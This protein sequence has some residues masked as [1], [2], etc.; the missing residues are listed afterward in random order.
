MKTLVI[1][2]TVPVEVDVP[3]D[4]PVSEAEIQETADWRRNDWS[5]GRHPFTSEQL[6]HAA[7][8][9]ARLDIEAAIDQHYCRRIDRAFPPNGANFHM[10]AR[11]ALI[12]RCSKTVGFLR[13]ANGGTV[14][15]DVTTSS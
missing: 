13:L 14:E 3:D 7:S 8:H 4:F 2:Y 15:I 1:R 5:D 6:F 10:E 12:E 9:A 11:N